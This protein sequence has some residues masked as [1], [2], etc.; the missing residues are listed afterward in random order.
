VLEDPADDDFIDGGSGFD[1]MIVWWGY[2][3]R[4]GA[5]LESIEYFEQS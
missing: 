3:L 5:H 4:S 1:T 2:P